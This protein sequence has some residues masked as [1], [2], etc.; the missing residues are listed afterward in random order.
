MSDEPEHTPSQGALLRPF[1][2]RDGGDPGGR[3]GHRNGGRPDHGHP[4]HGSEP[5]APPAAA[6]TPFGPLRPFVVTAG[7][8]ASADTLP[9]ETQVIATSRGETAAET[10][11]FEYRDIVTLCIE[12]IAVAEIAARLSLHLGVTRV[13]IGD[14]Q[15]QGMVTT[16]APESDAADDV[17][18]IMRVIHGL[19]QLG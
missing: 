12:P 8:T 2:D 14:L 7:R 5:A 4:D 16:H 10:L 19:R 18:T 17:E 15:D 13:L 3:N 1:L 11:S 9:V 6:G